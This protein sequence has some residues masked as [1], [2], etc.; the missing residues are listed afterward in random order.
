M[1]HGGPHPPAICSRHSRRKTSLKVCQRRI[2]RGKPKTPSSL[3]TPT[4][5]KLASGV[6]PAV[7]VPEVNQ[8]INGLKKADNNKCWRERR[9]SEHSHT[10]GGNCSDFGRQSDISSKGKTQR[11]R[12]IQQFHPWVYS[13]EDYKHICTQKVACQCSSQ[14]YLY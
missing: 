1:V 6:Y 8:L 13:Q 2:W 10:A 11:Y 7:N 9:K 14:R 5:E 3:T 12:L 4:K